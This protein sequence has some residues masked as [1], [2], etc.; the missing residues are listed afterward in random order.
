MVWTRTSLLAA[1]HWMV[2][3]SIAVF[4]YDPPLAAWNYSLPLEK[5]FVAAFAARA[6]DD[7]FQRLKGVKDRPV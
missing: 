4:R 5:L 2:G 6:A 7:A 3:Q 1:W